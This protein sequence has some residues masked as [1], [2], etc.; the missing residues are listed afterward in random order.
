MTGTDL[1]FTEAV[2]MLTQLQ[3]ENPDARFDIELHREKRSKNAN[4]YFWE[5]VSKI[6]KKQRISDTEVHDH[7]LSDNREYYRNEDGGIDWKV[8]CLEPNAYGLIVEK[9]KDDYAYYID[10]KMRVKLKKPDGKNAKDK[11]G[12]DVVGIVYWHIKG[13]HQMTRKEMSRIIDSAIF[14]AKKLDIEVEPPEKINMMLDL[15]KRYH[16]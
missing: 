6:A 15:W 5:L 3:S 1:T 11:D 2:T 14:E 8:S 13:T 4:S 12:N 16:G 7:L 10:S 9:V